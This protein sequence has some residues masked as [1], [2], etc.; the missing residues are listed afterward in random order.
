MTIRRK[1]TNDNKEKCFFLLQ[2]ENGGNLRTNDKKKK[3]LF[4]LL[5]LENGESL[6][7]NDKNKKCYFLCLN[8]E[9][10]FFLHLFSTPAGSRIKS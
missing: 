10:Q 4:R 2:L 7:T 6:R 8:F 9:K 3:C 5:Q 1:Q